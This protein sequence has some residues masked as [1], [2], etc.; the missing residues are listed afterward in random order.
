MI[1][2]ERS[3]CRSVMQVFIANRMQTNADLSG[4][5]RILPVHLLADHMTWQ[6]CCNL[7]R[8]WCLLPYELWL[9]KK[10]DEAETK[11][12]PVA[13]KTLTEVNTLNFHQNDRCFYFPP[14]QRR[15]QDPR[16]GSKTK[17]ET[18]DLRGLCWKSNTSDMRFCHNKTWR[19]K[20][21]KRTK[22]PSHSK[23]LI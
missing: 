21:E 8:N 2:T 14:H 20:Q 19:W 15:T 12:Q 1:N 7:S 13:R 6:A 10:S 16:N 17:P 5:R 18:Q 23:H 11:S 22:S 3:R 4:R 9:E